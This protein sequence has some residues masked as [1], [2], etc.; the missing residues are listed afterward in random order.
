MIGVEHFS[1]IARLWLFLLGDAMTRKL[2]RLEDWITA[3]DSARLLSLKHNRPINP[4]Y[5]R[6]LSRSKKQPIRT[7]QKGDRLLY[8]RA[9]IEKAFIQQKGH[10][11]Q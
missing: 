11:V 4:K 5:I 3:K 2:N 7:E 8:Y 1:H 9:D 10:H 6:L